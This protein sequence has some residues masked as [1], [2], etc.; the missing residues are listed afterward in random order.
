MANVAG[1]CV[2]EMTVEV[3][4]PHHRAFPAPVV[5]ESQPAKPIMVEVPEVQAANVRAEELKI[6]DGDPADGVPQSPEV[7]SRAYPV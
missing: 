1:V 3:H 5:A 2:V 7:A 6:V 4:D